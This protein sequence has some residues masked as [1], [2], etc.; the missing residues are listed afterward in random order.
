VKRGLDVQEEQLR[1][2]SSP[3]DP[4]WGEEPRERWGRLVVGEDER[5]VPTERGSYGAFYTGVAASLNEGAPPPVDPQDA[6]AVLE[7]LD[8]ARAAG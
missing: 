5:E 8:E 4:G 6:V 7:L 2:G 3:T 1:T